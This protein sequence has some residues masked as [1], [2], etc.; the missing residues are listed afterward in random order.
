MDICFALS[1]SDLDATK[2][3]KKMQE[4][5]KSII[6]KYK[7]YEQIHYSVLP[8]GSRPVN[9]IGFDEQFDSLERLMERVMSLPSASWTTR[10]CKGA[11]ESRGVV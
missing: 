9:E 3:L 2:T 1:T 4:A 7:E 10:P 6:E 8:F 5:V 11:E